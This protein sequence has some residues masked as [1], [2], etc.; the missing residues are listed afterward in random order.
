MIVRKGQ[1]V[2]YYY[3]DD[4]DGANLKGTDVDELIED[5]DGTTH[6]ITIM[7]VFTDMRHE[8]VTPIS[9]ALV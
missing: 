9:P 3:L 4:D 2:E 5:K 1:K 6:L 8:P 7:H